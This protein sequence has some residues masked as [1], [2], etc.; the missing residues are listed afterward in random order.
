MPSVFGTNEWAPVTANCSRGCLHDCLYCYAKAMAVRFNRCRASD[1]HQE[2]TYL[3]RVRQ[4]ARMAP[5]RVMFPSTHDVTP[6]VLPSFLLGSR[7]LLDAGHELLV[8]TK[9]HLDCMREMCQAFAN[10]RDRVMMR[11][12]IG[13]ADDSALR[14]WEPNAPSAQERVA[15]LELARA[16]GFATS[17]SCEPMLDAK[18]EDL[19]ELVRPHV[20]HS[21]WIGK[22]NMLMSRLGTNGQADEESVARARQ[23][24]EDLTDAYIL[25]LHRKLA[26]DPVI[27]WK[28]SIKKVLGVTAKQEAG[29]TTV[30]R[31]RAAS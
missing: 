2:H 6:D 12:T 13:S 17:V 29:L 31:A 7:M 26:G 16:S 3:S 30:G 5:T 20:T 22:P 19:V 10:C 1:W 25:E 9:A 8:V 23:L 18:T 24:L 4:V 11:V 27:E 28:E 21:I 14:F 15:A